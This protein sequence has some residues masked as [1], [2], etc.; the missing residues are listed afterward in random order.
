MKTYF[1]TTCQ[2][3]WNKY[4]LPKTSF[5]K[6]CD[7][8]FTNLQK[9]KKISKSSKTEA[10]G[11][12]KHTIFFLA[13]KP[14]HHQCDY[15]LHTWQYKHQM[16]FARFTCKSHV[17]SYIRWHDTVCNLQHVGEHWQILFSFSKCNFIFILL[18]LLYIIVSAW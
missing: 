1:D 3:L 12:V 15:V 4:Q 10:G 11:D 5:N 14:N 2:K 16:R 17:H 6:S 9:K 13:W 7:R 8:Y 18:Y